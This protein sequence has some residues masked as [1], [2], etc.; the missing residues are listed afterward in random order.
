[1]WV[2]AGLLLVV[3]ALGAGDP[4]PATL[5]VA[6]LDGR[7][8][9]VELAGQVTIVDFFA[10]WCP[11]CRESLADYPELV[12]SVGERA[13]IIVVDVEEPP[14]TVRAFFARHPLP[15]GVDLV[16]D[17]RGAAVRGFGPKAYPSLYVL[18]A[19][20]VV[21][22]V[23]RGWGKGSAED[24]VACVRQILDGPPVRTRAGRK[25]GAAQARPAPAA[26]EASS[27]DERAR[28]MGVE[29]LH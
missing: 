26:A 11:H 21:H 5:D 18:D 9:A 22:D 27:A 8:T 23:R 24:L 14:A 2:S 25:R 3:A 29:I 6:T 19:S 10:T 1:M 13:R 16:L 28:S 12:A 4:A 20:G 15:F 7:R 17:P